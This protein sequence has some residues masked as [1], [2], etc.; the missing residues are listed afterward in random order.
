MAIQH[1]TMS[2]DGPSHIGTHSEGPGTPFFIMQQLAPLGV[3]LGRGHVALA[4]ASIIGEY[5]THNRASRPA[6]RLAIVQTKTDMI[7]AV[8]G[9]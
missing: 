8:L 7:L 3:G 5:A 9:E 4:R 1:V 6:N 2:T